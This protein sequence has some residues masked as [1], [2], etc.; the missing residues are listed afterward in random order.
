M[1]VMVGMVLLVGEVLIGEVPF[2]DSLPAGERGPYSI[3]IGAAGI[4][5]VDFPSAGVAGALHPVD[6]G[7]ISALGAAQG[8]GAPGDGFVGLEH[9]HNQ[10]SIR[11]VEYVLSSHSA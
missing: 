4:A 1:V 8:D 9:V 7:A 10:F 3:M 5:A 2:F 6:I 11:V